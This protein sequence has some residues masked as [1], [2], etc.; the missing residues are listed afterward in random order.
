MVISIRQWLPDDDLATLVEVD[1]A[2]GELFAAYGLDLPPDDPAALLSEVAAVLVAEVESAVVG[3]AALDEADALGYLA[4]LAVLPAFGR[5]GVGSALLSAA[6]SW[7]VRRGFPAITLTTFTDVPWNAPWYL[8]RGFGP[9]P[10]DRWGPRLREL[11][12]SQV[13]AG[14]LVAPRLAMIRE[15]G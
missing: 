6:C 5:R 14:I 3:F 10:A 2:A 8:A 9:F 4:E 12:Q 7:A 15:L 1:R 13:Q 11:W